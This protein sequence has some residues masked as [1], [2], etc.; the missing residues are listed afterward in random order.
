MLRNK[1]NYLDRLI[2]KKLDTGIKEV[3]CSFYYIWITF[4]DDT[5]SM[6][7]NANKYHAWLDVGYIGRYK[8]ENK[9]PSRA[10][11]RRLNDCLNKFAGKD[12]LK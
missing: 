10:T 1:C 7:W 9:R 8:W 2:N 5:K 11:M 12:R 3:V 4:N 6:M